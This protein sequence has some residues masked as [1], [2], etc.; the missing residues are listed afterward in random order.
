[1]FRIAGGDLDVASLGDTLRR[2]CKERGL[3]YKDFDLSSGTVAHALR[4]SD[5]DE[6]QVDTVNKIL[7]VMGLTRAQLLL[8]W[9]TKGAPPPRTPR[10]LGDP[11]HGIPIINQAPA[12]EIRD[13]HE[14]SIDSGVGF[15]YIE[16]GTL[17][18]DNLFA[19]VITGPSMLP[20]LAEGDIVV[21]E[22]LQPDGRIEPGEVVYARLSDGIGDGCTVARWRKLPDGRVRL[23]KDNPD[24]APITCQPGDI[25][26][27]AAMI[28]RR[29][30]TSRY[31]ARRV[32]R[33]S[34]AD[35]TGERRIERD[36]DAPHGEE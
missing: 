24:F 31:K 11:D 5:I 34:D 14:C 15:T 35:L 7:R 36:G 3:R 23:E 21:F 18:G 30:R 27:L 20:R 32:A 16:R 29:E 19:V 1:M 8:E 25:I 28:E 26:Q 2:L 17:E 6:L 9:K 4:A 12:G 33:G 22:Q 13:Y 10:T